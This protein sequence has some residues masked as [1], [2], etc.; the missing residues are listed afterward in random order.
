MVDSSSAELANKSTLHQGCDG[1]DHVSRFTSRLLSKEGN[2]Q[3]VGPVIY[4]RGVLVQM[5]SG[6]SFQGGSLD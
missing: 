5:V 3:R 2:R 6:H 4:A 1:V